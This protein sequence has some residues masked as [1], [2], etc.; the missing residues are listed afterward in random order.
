MNNSFSGFKS[1]MNIATEQRINENEGR[2]VEN[3]QTET[4][5]KIKNKKHERVFKTHEAV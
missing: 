2:A 4:Q 3:N 1:K 5:A